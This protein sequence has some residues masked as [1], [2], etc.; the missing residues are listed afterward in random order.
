MEKEN[1]TSVQ[2]KN[3]F[4]QFSLNFN[5]PQDYV[6][7]VEK[8]FLHDSNM[9][10]DKELLMLLIGVKDVQVIENLSV[11]CERSF[12]I[13]SKMSIKEIENLKIE[14]MS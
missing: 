4:L 1:P 6:N 7:T 12:R 9:M 5:E 8:L 2:A 13:L 11:A 3:A 14:R 10:T